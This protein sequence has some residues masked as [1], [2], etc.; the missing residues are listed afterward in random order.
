MRFFT[1]ILVIFSIVRVNETEAAPL[2]FNTAL[3]VSQNEFIIREQFIVNKSS[4]DPSGLGRDRTELN[5][6]S[7]IV[8]GI[9]PD[10]ALF[11]TVV[12]TDRRLETNVNTRSSR[13]LGDTK[14]FGRYT[15]YQDDFKGGTFRIAP[16]LGIK[17]PTGKSNESDSLGVLPMSIQSGTGSWDVFGGLVTT[18]GT[19]NWEID[20]QISYQKNNKANR[21]KVGDIICVDASLQYRLFPTKLSSDTDYFVNGVIEANLIYKMKNEVNG[22][23]NSNSGGITLFIAPAIQYVSQNWIVEAIIQIPVIQNLHGTALKNDFVLRTGFRVN[24]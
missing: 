18:Y 15:V 11:T 13:G 21:F 14:L 20:N 16:F 12:Y 22:I 2:T 23:D 10:F 1:L 17:I 7:T 24:F 3:P 6:V 19:V 5:V 8:Y 4:N 9:T